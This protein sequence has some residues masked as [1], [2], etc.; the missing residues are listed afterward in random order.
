[1]FGHTDDKGQFHPHTKSTKKVRSDQ[2]RIGST[3]GSQPESKSKMLREEIVTK[4]QLDTLFQERKEEMKQQ[5]P[6]AHTESV[7]L[8]SDGPTWLVTTYESSNMRDGD[9]VG[10]I[11]D[12]YTIRYVGENQYKIFNDIRNK[13]AKLPGGSNDY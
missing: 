4:Q 9:Y 7:M 5:H 6:G 3:V 1:M 10:R 8:T 13:T 12:Q 2:V 11:V